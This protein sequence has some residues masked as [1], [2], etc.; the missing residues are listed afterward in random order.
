ML[1]MGCSN[2]IPDLSESEQEAVEQYAAVML[3]QYDKQYKSRLVSLP[4]ETQETEETTET[5]EIIPSETPPIPE[6][7][8]ESQPPDPDVG[9]TAQTMS[10]EDFLGLPEGVTVAFGGARTTPIYPDDQG[11][12]VY[13]GVDA[14]IGEQLLV[15]KFIISNQSEMDQSIDILS[16]EPGFSVTVNGAAKARVM[17]TLLVDDLTTYMGTIPKGQGVET[18]LLANI[19]EN[20]IPELLTLEGTNGGITAVILNN[21]DLK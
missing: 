5:Q 14:P 8:E 2:A 6:E 21:I 1:L 7:T 10:M 4:E 13:F 19:P 12:D 11:T 20:I 3:M 16:L 9:S 15:L 18:I 17:T